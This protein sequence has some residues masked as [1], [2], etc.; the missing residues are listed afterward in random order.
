MPRLSRRLPTAVLALLFFS[1]LAVAAPP[2]PGLAAQVA[3]VTV[4]GLSSG[5][6][7]AVQFQ[8]AHA[9]RVRGAG[10]L[11]GGPYD[12]AAGS[13]SRALANCMAPTARE[14][15]P[16]AVDTLETLKNLAAAGRIDPPAALGDDR[17]WL[18]VGERDQTVAPAVMDALAAFYRAVLPATALRYVKLAGAGHAMPS[19]LV[20]PP[21]DCA[22]SAPPYLNRCRDF[23]AAGQLLDHLL[24]PLRPPD[25]PPA[26]ELIAFDQRP[27]IDRAAIDASLADEGYAFVPQACRGGGCRVHVAFHGCRQQAGEIGRRFVEEAGYNGWA[28]SNRLIVLYPQTTARYGLAFGSGRWLFN[29]KGCWDWWGYT[30]RDYP[31]RDGVQLRA[32]RAMVDALGRPASRW[33]NADLFQKCHSRVG[34]NPV[35]SI[36]PGFPPARERQNE[37]LSVWIEL[38]YGF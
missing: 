6:H 1:T 7:M 21:D 8:V 32:V 13:L 12:C 31:T 16:L 25:A 17:V 10:I 20:R 14:Q 38:H 22:A 2:L 26:G 24:G 28:S 33:G 35:A 37:A 19:P 30:G 11:A 15:P 23:D 3:E 4:S 18:F 27:F 29:P 34:G 36:F 9:S 5:G